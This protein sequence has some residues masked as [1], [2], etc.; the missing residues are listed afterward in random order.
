MTINNLL[1]GLLTTI[2]I[3]TWQWIY[4]A[5]ARALGTYKRL[6]FASIKATHSGHDLLI[7][8][9]TQPNFISCK[10][11]CFLYILGSVFC[12]L[13][14]NV[15]VYNKSGTEHLR[16]GLEPAVYKDRMRFWT[17]RISRLNGLWQQAKWILTLTRY[18][19]CSS[20]ETRIHQI[21]T[22]IDWLNTVL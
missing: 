19:W 21:L 9:M 8:P 16:A 4:T 11:Y 20:G 1:P 17:S 13:F 18:L 6:I 3:W 22:R 10:W 2:R 12:Y 7:S 15:L 14:Y 5:E